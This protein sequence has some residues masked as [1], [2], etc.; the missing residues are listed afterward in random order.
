[1]QV[2]E[3]HLGSPGVVVS[4]YSPKLVIRFNRLTHF[5]NVGFI[6]LGFYA[7]FN[8]VQVI[9]RRVVLRAEE[10]STYICLWFCTVNC[11]PT[12]SNYQPSHIRSEVWTTDL[13]GGWRVCYHCATVAYS[14]MYE[15]SWK[16]TNEAYSYISLMNLLVEGIVS[17]I[18]GR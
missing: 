6:Y 8:T 13:R 18:H 2:F 1:M 5:E 7:S 15:K 12:A 10:T 9:S 16:S 11:R 17:N 3:S 14:T 4:F